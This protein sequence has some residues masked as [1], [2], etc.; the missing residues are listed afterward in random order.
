[1]CEL[2]ISYKNFSKFF[3]KIKFNW[4]RKKWKQILTKARDFNN[5]QDRENYRETAPYLE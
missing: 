1:M 5:K 4:L 3:P 2:N